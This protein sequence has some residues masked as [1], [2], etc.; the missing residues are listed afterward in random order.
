ML[1]TPELGRHPT[2]N[3]AIPITARTTILSNESPSVR[4]RM[5]A[6]RAIGSDLNRSIN[7]FFISSARPEA[8]AA[9]VKATVCTKIP[10]IKS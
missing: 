6:E 4:P 1:N 9:N 10:G 3:P 2:T 8:V 5:R 7:P